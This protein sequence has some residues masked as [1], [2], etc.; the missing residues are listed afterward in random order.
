MNTNRNSP[1]VSIIIPTHNR[2]GLLPDAVESCLK[3]TWKNIEII[4]VDDGS[5]DGTRELVEGRISED[6]G[7]RSDENGGWAG[8]NIRYENQA[9]AGASVARNRGLQM[10]TGDYVQFL[11]SDDLLESRKL[12]LQVTMLESA[13]YQKAAGCYCYGRFTKTDWDAST[14]LGRKCDTVSELLN[15]LVSREIFVMATEAP[16]WRRSF[17]MTQRGW[18]V[19]IGLGDDLEYHVRL[20][21]VA[22]S[23]GFI[24]QD[25]FLVREHGGPRLSDSHKNRERILSLI[26]TRRVVQEILLKSGRWDPSIQQSFLGAMR[27]YYANIL[28]CG[29]PDDLSQLEAFLLQL[30]RKPAHHKLFPALIIARKIFGRHFILTAHR[31][32]MKLKQ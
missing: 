28:D 19:D 8:R 4:I 24:T 14:R 11:D 27:T 13:D 1:L 22:E 30:S 10:A 5:T 12:E 29:N 7:R 17:L 16:L 15:A 6:R 18:P 32:M 2:H 21:C 20:L 9:N 23:M 25:L 31:F 26:N 3:Q